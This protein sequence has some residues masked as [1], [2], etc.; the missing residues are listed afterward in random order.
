M[1]A[2]QYETPQ[3][4]PIRFHDLRYTPAALLLQAGVPLVAVQQV[5]GTRI[6]SSPKHL[7]PI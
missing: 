6:P 7:R 1:P 3:V 4:R 5:Y 2:L